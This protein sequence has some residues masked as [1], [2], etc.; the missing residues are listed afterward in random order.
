MKHYCIR[1]DSNTRNK[2]QADS[3][4]IIPL[5]CY[6]PTIVNEVNLSNCCNICAN[7][8]K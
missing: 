2:C 4:R 6:N 8:G 1:F 5:I 3:F 7:R